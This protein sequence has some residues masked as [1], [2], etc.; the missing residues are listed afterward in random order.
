MT[1]RSPTATAERSAEALARATAEAMFAADAC[2]RGLGIELLE[3]R[4]G[5]ART[6]MP[7]RPD[8]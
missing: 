4:P 2:S 8:F 3:V 7:V 6:C 1:E 5:Y